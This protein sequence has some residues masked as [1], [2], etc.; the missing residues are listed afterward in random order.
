V[1]PIKP[2]FRY[3]QY[4]LHIHLKTLVLSQLSLWI[5]P[6]NI[7]I[8]NDNSTIYHSH[9]PTQVV[10]VLVLLIFPVFKINILKTNFK[11]TL[12]IYKIAELKEF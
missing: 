9:R 2:A 1:V 8:V 6:K 10:S 7:M 11:N 4:K 3:A 5:A 12:R